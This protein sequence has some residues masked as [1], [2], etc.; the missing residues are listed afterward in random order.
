MIFFFLVSSLLPLKN[1]TTDP[2]VCCFLGITISA[3]SRKGAGPRGL[4]KREMFPQPGPLFPSLR[5]A[6]WAPRGVFPAPRRNTGTAVPAASAVV[7]HP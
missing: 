7:S 2:T 6:P 3:K 5:P 1:L 4:R